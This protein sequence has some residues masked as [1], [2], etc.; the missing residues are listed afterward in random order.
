MGTRR[1]LDQ[2]LH[3]GRGGPFAEPALGLEDQPMRQHRLGHFLD[4]VGQGVIAPGNRRQCLGRAEERDRRPRTAAEQDVLVVTAG[5]HDFED[6]LLHLVVDV[7][8]AN[9]VLAG[10]SHRRPSRP[11]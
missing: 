5:V 9:R 11:V 8:V 10:G 2:I 6:V 7:D 1:I 3:H 4:V